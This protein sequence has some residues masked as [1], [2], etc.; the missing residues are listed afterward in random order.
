LRSG[1]RHCTQQVPAGRPEGRNN[2]RLGRWRIVAHRL[3]EVKTGGRRSQP[4]RVWGRIAQAMVG[5]G[6][7]QAEIIAQNGGI[8]PLAGQSSRNGLAASELVAG[9]TETEASERTPCG[10]RC[11]RSRSAPRSVWVWR[12]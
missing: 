12:P 11:L 1:E 4:T 5:R 6:R 3:G 9:S 2:G 7:T 8:L 10:S